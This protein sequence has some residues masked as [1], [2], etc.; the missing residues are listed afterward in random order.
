MELNKFLNRS[1]KRGAK[2]NS[3]PVIIRGVE[4]VS[5]LAASR[6]IEEPFSFVRRRVMNDKNKDYQLVNKLPK[7]DV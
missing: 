2:K 3:K 4:Y 5:I 1:L 6:E 7:W